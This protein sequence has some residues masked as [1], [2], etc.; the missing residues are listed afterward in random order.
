MS[1]IWTQIQTRWVQVPVEFCKYVSFR[2]LE[3]FWVLFSFLSGFWVQ[4]Q[5]KN[6]TDTYLVLCEIDTDSNHGYKN[7]PEPRPIRSKTYGYKNEPE[8]TSVH[9]ATCC[10]HANSSTARLTCLQGKPCS[11]LGLA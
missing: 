9:F 8:L 3:F 1:K 2:V 10:P 5:V 7:E 11:S 6:E 4:S